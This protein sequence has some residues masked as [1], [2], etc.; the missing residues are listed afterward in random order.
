MQ[1]VKSAALPR[2]GL[3]GNPSDLYGG[4]GIA[5][6]F[7]GFRAEVELVAAPATQ[8]RGE[9]LDA[10]WSVFTAFA[11]TRGLRAQDLAANA[12]AASFHSDIP[13]QVGL[14][15]SSAVLTAFVRA[16]ARWFDLEL[17]PH[18]L[19]ELTWRAEVD[20]LGIR[21]GPMD[22]LVQAY[23]GLVAMDFVEPFTERSTIRLPERLLPP[24]LIAWDPTPGEES[25]RVHAPVWERW[26]AGDRVVREV[27]AEYRPL[28][29][30]GLA[31]LQ[32]G[33]LALLR[34]LVD[35]N[36]DLRARVFA[37]RERDRAM[38]ELGRRLGAAT[39]FC[40]SGGA[41]LVLPQDGKDLEALIG[42]YAAAGFPSLVAEVAT[43]A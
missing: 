6:T 38:I 24:C 8:M 42:A 19:A 15:G 4:R 5:F 41:V 34:R 37:I 25:G 17:R 27:L 20:V 31:A 32:R 1:R 40:G 39:K 9:L 12:F 33:D 36:W 14:A 13:R 28:V 29:E 7:A 23:E 30:Q 11:R 2:A 16:L 26:Q 18:E 35:R 22:R 21:A 10:G 3:L 43:C